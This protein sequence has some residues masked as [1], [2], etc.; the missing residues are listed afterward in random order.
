[1]AR[2]EDLARVDRDKWSTTRVADI[3]RTDLP[4]ATTSWTVADAIRAMDEVDADRLA[5]CDGTRFVGVIGADE[6]V[7]LDEI[8]RRSS[9]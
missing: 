2:A 3:M 5:V 7:K 1:M 4:V 6:I 9:A 8:L